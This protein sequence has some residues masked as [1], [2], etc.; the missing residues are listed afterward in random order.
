MKEIAKNII[1]DS[2]K[3]GNDVV[4]VDAKA[5]FETIEKALAN[6]PKGCS[7]INKEIVDLL[8]NLIQYK[9]ENKND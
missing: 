5:N 7:K 9:E 4:V 1:A 8:R 3:S 6:D 2:L